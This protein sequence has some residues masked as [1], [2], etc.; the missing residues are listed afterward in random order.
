VMVSVSR[1]GGAFQAM[2]ETQ[3]VFLWSA[4]PHRFGQPRSTQRRRPSVRDE[5]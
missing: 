2:L 3:R 4:V 1:S 5:V